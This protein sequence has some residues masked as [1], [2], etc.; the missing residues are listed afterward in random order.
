MNPWVQS[1]ASNTSGMVAHAYSPVAWEVGDLKLE[2]DLLKSEE[3]SRR[4]RSLRPF[5]G[6]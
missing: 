6:T 2:E 5:F 4:L 1:P 3:T